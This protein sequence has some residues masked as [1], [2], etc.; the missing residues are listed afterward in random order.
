MC[1]STRKDSKYS[2]PVQ[3]NVLPLHKQRHRNSCAFGRL[4]YLCKVS[5]QISYNAPP[6]EVI[7]LMPE[8]HSS[9]T[10]HITII[11]NPYNNFAG[12]VLVFSS[13]MRKI[14]AQ[15]QCHQASKSMPGLIFTSFPLS[16]GSSHILA[17]EKIQMFQYGFLSFGIT[18]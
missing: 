13:Q 18:Q 5:R 10:A 9:G 14:K 16:R 1:H 7:Y 6:K 11:F 17:K 12:E 15:S 8:M 2:H 4:K 3:N